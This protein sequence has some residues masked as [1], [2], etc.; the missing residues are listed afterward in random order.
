MP[1]R[2]ISPANFFSRVDI[3]E[4]Q[5]HCKRE[6]RESASY[7]QAAVLSPALCPNL[8]QYPTQRRVDDYAALEE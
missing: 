4:N 3:C 6:M 8:E 1:K 5:V 2:G 7:T